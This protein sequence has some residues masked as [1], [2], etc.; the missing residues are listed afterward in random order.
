MVSAEDMK[1]KLDAGRRATAGW[2]RQLADQIETLPIEDAAELLT[3]VGHALEALAVARRPAVAGRARSR[4]SDR[5][6][7]LRRRVVGRGGLGHAATARVPLQRL[8]FGRPPE[9][10]VSLS[11]KARGDRTPATCDHSGRAR[12]PA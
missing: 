7:V 5:R 4:R 10:T 8:R 2:L 1:A 6:Q 12:R 9:W 3:W 11:H